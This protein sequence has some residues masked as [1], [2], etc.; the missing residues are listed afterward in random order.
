LKDKK[1]P[2]YILY[3]GSFLLYLLIV[4]RSASEYGKNRI[5]W[6][7]SLIRTELKI[8]MKKRKN[9]DNTKIK[10]IVNSW[11]LFEPQGHF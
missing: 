1:N 11:C 8:D 2:S 5:V 6:G 10:L 7:L 3:Y 4:R 9:T